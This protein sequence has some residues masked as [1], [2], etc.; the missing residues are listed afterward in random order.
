MPLQLSKFSLL[1]SQ[2]GSQGKRNKSNNKKGNNDDNNES[3][4]QSDNDQEESTF[5]EQRY[6]IPLSYLND[7]T[8]PTP[9]ELE[10]HDQG[11]N[12]A[13]DNYFPGDLE[14]NYNKDHSITINDNNNKDH[15][16]IGHQQDDIYLESSKSDNYFAHP[17]SPNT[18]S[19]P[20]LTL[21]SPVHAST[22]KKSSTTLPMTDPHYHPTSSSSPSSHLPPPPSQQKM[23][24]SSYENASATDDS[25]NDDHPH[26]N[27]LFDGRARLHWGKTLDKIRLI[28]NF[29]KPSH[30]LHGAD[31]ETSAALI[32]YCPAVFEPP[33][34]ALSKDVHGRRPPPI[35]FQ[36]L[37]INITDSELDTLGITQWAF[38]IE[39]QYG[40]VKWVLRRTI[41]DF[42]TLHYV[43][44]FKANVYDHVA[45][46]PS[47]PN[48]LQ[49]WINSAKETLLGED[50]RGGKYDNNKNNKNKNSNN[51]NN[52][53]DHYNGKERKEAALQ[54]RKELQKYLRK[55]IK[56][57]HILISY[58]ICEFLEISAISIV[59]DMGWKGKEGYLNNR[60]NFVTPRFCHMFRPHL[61]QKEWV[62]LRDSYIAFCKDIGST[63]PTDVLLLDKSFRVTKSGPGIL[64]RYH[65][66]ISLSNQ[67]RRIEIK[68]SKR[69]VEEWLESINKVQENSPWVKN[70]R[71]GSFAPIRHDSKVKWFVNGEAHFKAVSEAILSARTEIYIADWWL[72]PELYLRRP[73]E[74]NQ[75]FRLDNY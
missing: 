36:F 38:R 26:S 18:Q 17:F 9:V 40:D 3:D 8:L 72:S 41:A 56:N 44:K 23:L 48:Q 19:S 57:A 74:K 52:N 61:W 20:E 6:G 22:S 11:K 62:L 35:L 5:M 47:F 25:E 24:E 68:G 75:E 37:H 30:P 65:H 50:T 31:V 63:S 34:I 54:R 4:D 67:F 15:M 10:Q 43:L 69:D 21:P 49:P 27:T 70:H 28:S 58:D 32:P 71:F 29:Q 73:P 33:F 39:L 12:V 66:H 14:Y 59:Q 16:N 64:K 2:E 1:N 42:V 46:P 7:D 45:A 55:L 53:N 13:D 60:I 51:N